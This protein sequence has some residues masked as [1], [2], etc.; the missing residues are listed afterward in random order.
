MRRTAGRGA[1]CQAAPDEV[2]KRNVPVDLFAA[3]VALVSDVI[4]RTLCTADDRAA[5]RRLGA[6]N[7][8]GWELRFETQPSELRSDTDPL[9]AEITGAAAQPECSLCAAKMVG[10]LDGGAGPAR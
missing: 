9:G 3:L 8:P 4:D 10:F 5:L 1:R 2:G 6:Q 7:C